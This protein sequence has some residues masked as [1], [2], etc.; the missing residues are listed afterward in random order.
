MTE[1]SGKWYWWIHFW[2]LWSGFWLGI[3]IVQRD[4]P[5]IIIAG[6]SIA[7][8]TLLAWVCRPKKTSISSISI[9]IHET[10]IT[11]SRALGGDSDE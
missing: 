4:V 6:F 10:T 9:E 2:M 5:E 1:Q 8:W 11:R 7:A 3:G